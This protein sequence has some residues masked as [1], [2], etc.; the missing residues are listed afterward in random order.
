MKKLQNNYTTPEQ[1]ERLLE[2]GVPTDSADC[3]LNSDSVIM[4][5]GKTFQENYNEDLDFARLHLIE[6]PHYVPCWSVGR[7]IEIA[8]ICSKSRYALRGFFLFLEECE[9]DEC[10]S[11][12][13]DY[14]EI[15]NYQFDFSKLEE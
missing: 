11:Q 5:N 6:Y 15:C 2:L 7:L 14:F 3:C 12:V 10:M 1:S 9:A 13:M 8:K 4:L